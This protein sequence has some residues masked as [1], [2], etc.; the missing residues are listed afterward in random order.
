MRTTLLFLVLLSNLLA[1]IAFSQNATNLSTQETAI[2]QLIAQYLATR[3]QNDEQGLLALLTEDID[4][5]T[6]TGNLRSGRDEVGSGSLA[7]SRNNSGLRSI[8]VE[9]IRFIRPDVA[10]VNGP[11][12]IVG[13]NDGPD[14]HYLTSIVVVMEGEQWKIS[15]IRNMQPR[16]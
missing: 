10:I 2:T 11:Y 7:T 1:S 3:A 6:T 13:R 8:S 12:D 15:A 16:Q 5:L 4:Q 14:R 9:T